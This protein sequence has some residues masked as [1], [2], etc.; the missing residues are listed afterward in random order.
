MLYGATATKSIWDRMESLGARLLGR[1]LV[2]AGWQSPRRCLA[3]ACS[4]TSENGP[5]QHQTK[6]EERLASSDNSYINHNY[7]KP[8]TF[9]QTPQRRFRPNRRKQILAKAAPRRTATLRSQ[10]A[11]R[12]LRQKAS[13][14]FMRHGGPP[15]EGRRRQLVLRRRRRRYRHWDV[16]EEKNNINKKQYIFHSPC[17]YRAHADEYTIA[18]RIKCHQRKSEGKAFL[19]AALAHVAPTSPPSSPFKGLHRCSC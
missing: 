1:P 14:G 9:A 18:R 19:P 8:K 3:S 12:A 4:N 11:R 7:L 5:L 15:R 2:N 16:R 17:L 10:P 6:L 13:R